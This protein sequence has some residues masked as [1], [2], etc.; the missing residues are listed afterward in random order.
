MFIYKSLADIQLLSLLKDDDQLAFNE[1]YNRY[2][3]SLLSIAV[4]KLNDTQEAE[5]IM[6]DLFISL[7]ER[8]YNMPHILCLNNYLKGALRY[9][10]LKVWARR[11]QEDKYIFSKESAPSDNNNNVQDILN[12]KDL[13]YEIKKAVL[14]LPEKCRAVF[15]MSREDGMTQKQISFHLGISQKTVE[16]HISKAIKTLRSSLKHH[17]FLFFL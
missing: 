6:N 8:R 13:N 9:Q 16:A 12:L 2:W 5:D 15:E 17:F 4:K 11:H 3:K 7:W 14:D 1:I 10:V